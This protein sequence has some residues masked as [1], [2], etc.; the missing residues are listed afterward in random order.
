MYS[1]E[2]APPTPEVQ[3][4]PTIFRRIEKGDI[5]LPAFQRSF[6]WTEA[7][8]IK[9]LESV[10]KGYPIGSL[11]FWRVHTKELQIERDKRVPFPN[12]EEEYPLSFVLD[13]M[14]RLSSLFGVFR[15]KDTGIPGMFNVV[16]DLRTEVF[17]HFDPKETL[18][19]HLNLSA[20]FSPRQLLDVQRG[21]ME[22]PD[23]D[24]LID[25]SLKLQSIF[26]E[27]LLPTVTIGERD[28]TQVV[29]IFERVNSTG[30]QLSTVDFMRAMTWATQFDLTREVSELQRATITEGYEIPLETLVKTIA[31]ILHK[32]PTPSEM[33]GLRKHSAD[34]LHNATW[35]SEG[36]LQ[37]VIRFLK[38]SFMAYP[39]EFVPY[40][41][42]LL[43]LARLYGV[44][45]DPSP[46]LLETARRWFWAISFNEGLRGKPDH[47]V[48]RA[49]GAAERAAL[50]ELK[51]L[52]YQIDINPQT[53]INRRF[54]KGRALSAAVAS[55]LA[56]RGAR[57]LVSGEVIDAES[58][59]SEFSAEH[60]IGL[61]PLEVIRETVS[62]NATSSKI[63][64]NTILI[65]EMDRQTALQTTP[66]ALVRLL[67]KNFEDAE[68][69]QILES[70][71]ISPAAAE[72]VL[73]GRPYDFLLERA[74][75]LY[76][77]AS[78]LTSSD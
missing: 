8:I 5:R 43:V 60:F 62:N 44:A 13:G 52:N 61:Y 56:V 21:L 40:E 70:Q 12:V 46:Q 57:N 67:Y 32:A 77:G 58:Y 47:Y 38:E 29:E 78:A 3:Y 64:A 45:Q 2:L 39:Y 15:Q 65:P 20:L 76:E 74:R 7:Q 26:Q 34:E 25:R 72:M 1:R 11:L 28:I 16:F 18:G 59:M 17:S 4:L 37:R 50:G 33:L 41:G 48:T 9:L 30:T 63:F 42:Q 10:Y 36:I 75:M 68:A 19:S 54:I 73:E 27:Y 66:D 69:E 35:L 14:Q 55:M 22:Q 24:L 71:F 6:V 51:A 31:V 49:I 53:F 23:S